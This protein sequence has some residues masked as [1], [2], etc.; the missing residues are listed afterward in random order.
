MAKFFKYVNDKLEECIKMIK[1]DDF[2]PY[3]IEDFK[4]KCGCGLYPP[5]DFWVRVMNAVYKE[6]NVV[7]TVNSCI[8][9][10]KHNRDVG[11]LPNSAHLKG[12][13]CDIGY[14]KLEHRGLLYGTLYSLGEK[15]G[16]EVKR[17]II[18][19]NFMH[20]SNEQ[21]RTWPLIMFKL[22]NGDIV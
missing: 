4:C 15:Y 6:T 16:L 2:K 8:R 22:E 12:A 7:F 10:S 18:Y 20:I 19:E 21:H 1:E 3:S 14:T 13:A 9:C 17:G 5:D 11:G